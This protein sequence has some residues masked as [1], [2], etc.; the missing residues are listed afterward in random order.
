MAFNAND[1][2]LTL[3]AIRGFPNNNFSDSD[4]KFLKELIGDPNTTK[5]AILQ[6][7]QRLKSQSKVSIDRAISMNSWWRDHGGDLNGFEDSQSK[8]STLLDQGKGGGVNTPS[9]G[10]NEI[11][12]LHY[13]DL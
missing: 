12:D 1:A 2:T 10:N 4:L 11:T 9:S 6:N 8:P 5:Q 7:I 13:G 3:K